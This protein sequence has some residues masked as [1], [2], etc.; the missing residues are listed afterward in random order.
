MCFGTEGSS[1]AASPTKGARRG[2]EGGKGSG[3]RV[4]RRRER[5]GGLPA[6]KLDQLAAE[7]RGLREAMLAERKRQ[8]DRLVADAVTRGEDGDRHSWTIV[9]DQEMAPPSTGRALL[10]EHRIVPMPPQDLVDPDDLHDELWTVIE[11]L[12]ASGVH[13]LNTDHLTDRDLYARLYYRILDEPTR[14]MP[15]ESEAAEF[16]DCLHPMDIEVGRVAL[17]VVRRNEAGPVARAEGVGSRRGPACGRALADRDRWLPV[18]AW[19]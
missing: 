15:P 7:M 18:P 16:I 11:A 2:A 9:Y 12:A 14:L 8:I 5:A 1:E 6:C 17:A 10:L 4:M 3:V 19:G 13:L